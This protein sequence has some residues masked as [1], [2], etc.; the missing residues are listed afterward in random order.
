MI[1]LSK[2]FSLKP[3]LQQV[4]E[5]RHIHAQEMQKV[6]TSVASD[7]RTVNKAWASTY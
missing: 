2:D 1:V 3:V 7:V 6:T 5:R 4:L